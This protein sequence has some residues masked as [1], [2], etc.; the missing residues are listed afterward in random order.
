MDTLE[1]RPIGNDLQQAIL[2]FDNGF[3]VS[4][5]KGESSFSTKDAP[6]ELAVIKFIDIDAF[7][8]IYPEFTHGDVLKNL[9]YEDIKHYIKVTKT[10]NN[11]Q[12]LMKNSYL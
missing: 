7:E 9:T 2:R 1:F 12:V 10:L 5:I 6:F 8:L 4:I 11:N 3:G